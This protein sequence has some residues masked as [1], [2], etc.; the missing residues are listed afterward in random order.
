MQYMLKEYLS[1][2]YVAE[3]VRE[4]SEPTFAGQGER[5]VHPLGG[6]G[7]HVEVANTPDASPPLISTPKR[8]NFSITNGQP[9]VALN[10]H[11]SQGI[12]SATNQAGDSEAPSKLVAL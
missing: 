2:S 7:P 12:G 10:G 1:F 8:E 5:S 6:D 11:S 4:E 9:A 3:E